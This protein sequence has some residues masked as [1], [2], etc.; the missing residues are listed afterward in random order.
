[1][2]NTENQTNKIILEKECYQDSYIRNFAPLPKWHLHHGV[3]KLYS[4][5]YKTKLKLINKKPYGVSMYFF[6][7]TTDLLE[8]NPKTIA[9]RMNP[10]LGKVLQSLKKNWL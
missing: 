8:F 3:L 2:L 1:M 6:A 9:E 4:I 10:F 7:A 5:K